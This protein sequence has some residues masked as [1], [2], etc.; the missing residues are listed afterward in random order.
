MQDRKIYI[1]L[2]YTNSVLSRV[3]KYYT[4]EPYSHVSIAFD[5]ELNELY[6][7]GRLRP[8][9]PL[10]AGFVNEDI[11]NGTYARFKQTVYG[12]YTMNITDKQY[13]QLRKKISEFKRNADRSKYNL[14][15]LIGVAVGHPIAREDAYFCSQFVAEA[16]ETS[17]IKLF[18]K[19]PALVTPRDFRT[20]KYL[21]L[22]DS[23]KLL[24][25]RWRTY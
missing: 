15:G 11:E 24:D 17:G 1:L 4:K 5:I 19:P 23:G 21:K 18:D 25:Y 20:S 10:I 14:L 3:I 22:V 6:S 2:T 13:K 9:N 12:L 7:F 16:F 8:W